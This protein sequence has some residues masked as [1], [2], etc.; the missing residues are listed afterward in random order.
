M[1]RLKKIT[2]DSNNISSTKSDFLFIGMF[3]G[4]SL[5]KEA[6]LIDQSIGSA[7]SSAI[8]IEGFDG[9]K[10]KRVCIYNNG[11]ISKISIEGLGDKSKLTSDGLRALA[12]NIMRYANKP[13]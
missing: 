4:V 10:G 13:N 5:N 2:L 9:D 7:I 8:S 11:K 12:S 3:K 1:A 6:K